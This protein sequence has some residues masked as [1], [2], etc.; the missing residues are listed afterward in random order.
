MAQVFMTAHIRGEQNTLNR[1]H[2]SS[3]PL[4]VEFTL[5][6]MVKTKLMKYRYKIKET[7]SHAVKMVQN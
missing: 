2:C 1:T 3:D 7:L 6:M 4:L 5:Q